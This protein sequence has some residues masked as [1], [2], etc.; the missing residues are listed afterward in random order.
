M[1][2]FICR[3]HR[4]W[5]LEANFTEKKVI[6]MDNKIKNLIAISP[7]RRT[8]GLEGIPS[9]YNLRKARFGDYRMFMEVDMIGFII[10]CL[11][12]MHRSKCYDKKNINKAI[13]ILIKE[14]AKNTENN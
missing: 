8:D 9:E 7:M 1:W 3:W 5:F 6:A 14:R 4:G 2:S 13:R 11:S 10:T 12:F